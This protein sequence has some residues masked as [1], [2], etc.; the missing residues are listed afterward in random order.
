MDN[1]YDIAQEYMENVAVLENRI[2]ELE[3]QA[4]GNI[5][6]QELLNLRRRIKILYQFVCEGRQNA[7]NIEHYYDKPKEE[8]KHYV[9]VCKYNSKQKN[10]TAKQRFRTSGYGSPTP[11]SAMY[12]RN[13]KSPPISGLRSGF[14]GGYE[15]AGNRI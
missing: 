8:E 1:F 11:A 4:K 13:L 3:K 10:N 15:S 2:A 12:G 9:T 5:S 7:F 14:S 6:N